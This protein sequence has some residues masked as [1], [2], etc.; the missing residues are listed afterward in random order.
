MDGERI[1]R[2]YLNELISSIMNLFKRFFNFN[3]FEI[4]QAEIIEKKN[5][6]CV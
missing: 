3:S 4:Y 5:H 6:R 1:S 2:K